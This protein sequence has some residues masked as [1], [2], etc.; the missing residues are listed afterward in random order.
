MYSVKSLPH[1]L[2]LTFINHEGGSEEKG[3]HKDRGR[4]VSFL[5]DQRDTLTT[6]SLGWITRKQARGPER[7]CT[8]VASEK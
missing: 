6:S 1:S 3:A 8:Y 4:G 7:H 5:N 2:C